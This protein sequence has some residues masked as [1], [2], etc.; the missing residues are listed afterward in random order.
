MSIHWVTVQPLMVSTASTN[1]ASEM[2]SP[3]ACPKSIQPDRRTGAGMSPHAQTYA[4]V[5]T[6]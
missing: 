4:R 1:R 3:T 5:H 2:A 6:R